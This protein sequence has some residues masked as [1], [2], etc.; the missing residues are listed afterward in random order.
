MINFTDLIS[1]SEKLTALTLALTALSVALVKPIK[2]F[3]AKDKYAGLRDSGELQ[4]ILD[5]TR[6]AVKAERVLLFCAHDSGKLPRVGH[7]YYVTLVEGSLANIEEKERLFFKYDKMRVDS[8][9]RSMM[10]RLIDSSHDKVSIV[11]SQEPEGMLKTTYVK[12][13][14]HFAEVHLL[15]NR[16]KKGI[17]FMSVSTKAADGFSDFDLLA[18]GETVSAAKNKMAEKKW[19]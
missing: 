15:K 11:T 18:I 13:G 17:Y 16:G 6:E 19:L 14:I 2:W 12:E 4:L 7:P 10:V 9:Y 8:S 1:F 3:L 5:K